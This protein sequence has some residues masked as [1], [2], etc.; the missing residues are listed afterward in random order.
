MEHKDRAAALIAR[1]QHVLA[2]A[3]AARP[4]AQETV[5]R[6]EQRVQQAMLAQLAAEQAL[7]WVGPPFSMPGEPIKRLNREMPHNSNRGLEPSQQLSGKLI[8][9]RNPPREVIDL[10]K[11]GDCVLRL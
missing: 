8:R 1:N 7:R 9:C 5:A 10:A 2:E 11:T 3:T 6:A 4:R